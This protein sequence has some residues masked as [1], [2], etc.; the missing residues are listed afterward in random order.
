MRKSREKGIYLLTSGVL[1]IYILTGLLLT[2]CGVKESD[3]NLPSEAEHTAAQGETDGAAR[4]EDLVRSEASDQAETS[5]QLNESDASMGDLPEPASVYEVDWDSGTYYSDISFVNIEEYLARLETEGYKEINK[6]VAADTELK[7]GNTQ[8]MLSNGKELLQLLITVGSKD[9][10]MVNSILIRREKGITADMMN[11]RVGAISREEAQKLI[12]SEMD[13][14][15]ESGELPVARGKITG[16]FEIFLMEAFEKM[17]LQ[18]YTAISEYGDSGCFLICNEE[19]L[20]VIGNL[21]DTCVADLDGNGCYELL[22]LFGWGFGIYRIELS[23]YEFSNPIYFSS[24]TKVLHRKYYN[25]FVP[26]QGYGTL[27]FH[28]VSDSEVRLAGDKSDF[29]KLIIKDSY[30]LPENTQDFPFRQWKDVYDQ[31]R[32][33]EV[34]KKLPGRAPEI[35]VSVDGRSLDY[36]TLETKWDGKE[37]SYNTSKQF[38]TLLD[39]DA[40]LP[41]YGVG[42]GHYVELDF[43]ESIPDTIQVMDAMMEDSGGIRYGSKNVMDREVEIIDNS[44]V[45]FA[46]TQHIAYYLSSYSVDY[47]KDW[48]RLFHVICTWGEQ[49][50]VYTF[51][52]N[53]GYKEAVTEIENHD[54]LTCNGSYSMLSSSWGIGLWADTAKAALPGDYILEW[55]VSAGEIRSWKEDDGK[56][57]VITGTHHGYPM[58]SS[59]DENNGA[60]IWSPHSYEDGE[61]AVIKVYVYRSSEDK[62]PVAYSKLILS[63]DNGTWKEKK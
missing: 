38:Q 18:A 33:T 34:D 39:Q 50:A 10:S 42:A 27:K 6:T 57:V 11:G 62:S 36:L 37:N 26:N 23:A 61:E 59:S 1:V 9:N 63:C 24:L 3:A 8:R 51:V 60:V 32:L 47:E 48:Y 45:R 56:P 17:G 28:K 31:S 16:L 25:C 58:T 55:Q 2:S 35:V 5:E 29:G 15:V 20:P 14:M 53:T 52:L 30:L 21:K 13:R 46:L 54:F 22:D 4:S 44:R 49:E 41:T 19:V 12:Q 7:E 40:F 43:G